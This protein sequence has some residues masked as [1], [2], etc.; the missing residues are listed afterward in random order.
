[1]NKY[2]KIAIVAIIIIAVFCL[3]FF[4]TAKENV[5]TITYD[6]FKELKEKEAFIYFGTEKE[7][8]VL[9]VFAEDSDI[10]IS[11]LNSEDLSKG[12]IKASGLEKG[13]LYLYK[14]GKSVY[15]YSDEITQEKLVRSFMEEGFIDKNYIS[16]TLDEYLDII[17]EKGYHLMFIGSDSCSYCDM[18]K[19]SINEA[20]KNND[21]NVYYL[22]L[23]NVAQEDMEKLYA[24]DSY[25]TEE[26]WGTPLTFL[27]KNG[28]R[29]DVLNGYVETAELEEFLKEN[30]VI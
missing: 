16:I 22:N 25:L 8:E 9:E 10:E 30:K 24:T 7:K 14:D 19:E 28:K 15:E 26:E 12:E 20:L 27:Y 5:E 18:F 13:T 11:I 23:D 6:E 3:S 17:E 1:M 21:F 2:L 4:A 29:I